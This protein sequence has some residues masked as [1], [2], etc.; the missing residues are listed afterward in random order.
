M[1]SIN[2]YSKENISISTAAS[3]RLF[4]D[5]N[6]M[7]LGE[8]KK[9]ATYCTKMNI[10]GHL[11]HSVDHTRKVLL[12]MYVGHLKRIILRFKSPQVDS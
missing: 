12:I 1:I 10:E 7:G 2:E 11:E 3:K 9:Y 5:Q 6:I 4:R 8:I